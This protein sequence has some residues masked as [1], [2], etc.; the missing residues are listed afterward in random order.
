M[1]VCGEGGEGVRGGKCFVKL[2]FHVMLY[3]FSLMMMIHKSSKVA[4][5]PSHIG[6]T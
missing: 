3:L 1:C 6:A 4:R 5:H 2:A